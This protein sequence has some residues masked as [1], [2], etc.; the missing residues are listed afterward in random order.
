LPLRG[1]RA[2]EIPEPEE[3]FPVAV[4]RLLASRLL[5]RGAVAVALAAAAVLA[6]AVAAP[7]ASST[8]RAAGAARTASGVPVTPDWTSA[9]QN[10]QNT[11]DAASEQILGPGNVAGL[12]P[13]WAV[14][15][16]GDVA[17]TPTVA[18]GVVYVPDLGGNLWAVNAATGAVIWCKRVGDYTGVLGD[19]SRTSPAVSGGEIVIGDGFLTSRLVSRAGAFVVGID[20][21]SGALRW[22]TQVDSNPYAIVTSSPVIDQ[23]VVYVGVS[24]LEETLPGITHTFRGSV[25]ALDAQTGAI[26]WQTHTA[27]QGYTGNSVWGSSPVVDH[28]TG[29][30][31]VGTGNNYTVPAG[32]CST[33]GEV[34]CAPPV[35]DD[36]SDSVLG[37]NLTTG[38]IVWA[39]RTIA[40]DV[41]TTYTPQGPDDDF[42]SAPNLYTA[43]VNGT[44]TDLLGIGQKSG[45]YYALDPATGDVVWQTQV[46]AGGLDG[47]IEWGSATD[48]T[49]IYAAIADFPDP[50]PYTITSASG[51][52]STTT[53]GSVAALDAAT[54]KIL[55]QTADPQRAADL[56]FVSTANGVVYAGSDAPLG[57]TM[58]ALDAATGAIEWAYP[59]GGSVVSGAAIVNGSV[60]WGSGYYVG[61]DNNELYA[62]S[63]PAGGRPVSPHR[64]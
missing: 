2:R 36:Y 41:W 56:G 54:G 35:A 63:L 11:R 38:A 61:T 59:S 30:L 14:P 49:R 50:R 27:P 19:S 21:A 53:G 60:Y 52:T 44:P 4:S 48:G 40:L 42:G 15:T 22:R 18:D 9:G 5:A 17:A 64:Q 28:A 10:S 57:N 58:Y 26:I 39:H 62:F 43:I 20:A 34:G 24:S 25:V 1:E 7:L 31:Y 32:V 3:D 51:Q 23:G 33:S 16:G 37:L 46:G 47:G 29:L 55:W 45:R 13:R 8:Q 6:S 12:T